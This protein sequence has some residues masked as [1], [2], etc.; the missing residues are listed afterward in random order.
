[1]LVITIT[2]VTISQLS[3]LTL[4]TSNR[5]VRKIMYPFLCCKT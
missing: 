3:C 2:I 1:M 5:E 4:L